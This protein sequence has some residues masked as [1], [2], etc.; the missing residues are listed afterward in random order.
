MNHKVYSAWFFGVS[1][2]RWE[3]LPAARELSAKRVGLMSDVGS[4]INNVDVMGISQ[5]VQF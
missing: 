4:T 5:P 3:V 2:A 1:D